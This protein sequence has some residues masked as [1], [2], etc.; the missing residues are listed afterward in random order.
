[1]SYA[2]I[3]KR[4]VPAV[5]TVSAAKTVANR[6]PLMEDPFFRRFFGPQFGGPREQTQQ[7]LGS[8]VIV[9]PSGL[10]V[11]NNHV[12]DGADQVKISLADK[13]EFAVDVVLKDPRADLAVLRVKD[14][15]KERFPVIDFGNSDD[16]QVGDVVLAV[17]NPF[18]VGQTVT[19]GIVSAVAR[20][21][22]GI[23]DYQF[24]I[25]TDAAIN[26]GNSGGALVDMAGRLVGINT[27]IF[28]R[29]G[30]SQGV[31]FAIPATMVRLV[32]SLGA[33]RRQRGQAALARRQAPGADAGAV[34]GVQSAAAV[35]RGHHQRH[36][37][38][39]GGAGGAEGRRRHRLGRRPGGRRSQRL[40]LPLHD[41]SSSAARSISAWCAAARKARSRSRSRPRRRSPR[42]EILIE[43]RS[44]F[45]GAKVANL[46]P[47]L[48]DELRLDSSTEGVVVV[49]V[50]DG[51]LAQQFGF[52]RGDVL[53]A[54]NGAKIAKTARPGK[55]R[56]GRRPGL[57]HHHP[58]RRPADF[59]RV[60]RMSSRPKRGAGPSLFAAAG[61]DNDAPRPLADKLRPQK[62]ADVV[63]Q[64]HLLGP[65]GALTRMLD[66]RSLGSL[67]FWG[68]PGTGKTTVARLL[69]HETSLEFVQI[70]AIFS[71]VA[72]LK[73][74]FEE[75][76]ARREIG[77]GTLLFVDEIHRF[78]RAQQDSFLP[79][80]EDGTIVLVGA[81]TEN[82][83]FELIAPMLS[84]AR[85]LVFKSLDRRCGREAADPRRGARRQEAAAR[86]RR[87]AVARPHGRRRRPRLAHARRGNLA[88]RAARR[89]LR[90][91][92]LAEGG[93]AA[94]ADLRQE[95]GRP[96]QPD[97][98]AAQVGARL[99]SRRRAL[100]SRPHARRRRGPALSRAARGADGDRGH[101]HGR[102]AGAGDLQRR[103]GRLRFPGLARGR[104]RHRR[105]GDLCRDRAQIEC[106][107]RRLWRGQARGQGGRLAAAA[108]AHPQRADQSDEVGRL[109]PRLRL[110]P[111]R[112]RRRFPARTISRRSSAA[113]PST[114]RPSAASSAKS[115]SA[116]ITGRS[117]A[118][119]R[120]RATRTT[121]R[122]SKFRGQRN[123]NCA[124]ALARQSLSKQR[125]T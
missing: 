102:S 105:G 81:T 73:K 38:G 111:R 75:A 88:R 63:G 83:S 45:T 18:G 14:D 35:G 64:D 43:A 17:G 21:Q 25:Q 62:L 49:D 76:R 55:G 77:Q 79:V 28:S 93:A 13:R 125:K 50:A 15:G 23:S 120:P 113:R 110:R 34:A 90:R 1:M 9:D 20:T 82:P 74:V 47:A 109:R 46:S 10:I 78:N 32:V 22:V 5:V 118:R 6:N 116:W 96:L 122:A 56:P 124:V 70:S 98:G 67:I 8:G 94:R 117:F 103:Q 104:T 2:P 91:G 24:F 26:P 84:R 119:T 66:S 37:Q 97:L 95:A 51:T 42:D 59:S 33:L 72:D 36:R 61:L 58:A 4:V 27:A 53:L 80:M 54:V 7:S 107:L 57:A 115:G 52:Q 40:R 11:T 106:R 112:R 12:I 39:P 108:Q 87:A 101:R 19:H 85:V 121:S 3:V 86:R 100:L 89:D 71:G 48:A 41:A 31:G 30:G 69:A 99:R 92:G 44:P 114:I 65:D 68:P 16:L 60:R 29:S 123:E